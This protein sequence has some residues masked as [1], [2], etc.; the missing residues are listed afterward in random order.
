[1]KKQTPFQPLL[2]L[3]VALLLLARPVRA[4][5]NPT[6]PKTDLGEW[7]ILVFLN[8]DNNLEPDALTNFRQMAQV[9][10]NAKVNIIV[11]FDRNGG[12]ASTNPNWSQTLRF[13][14]HQGIQPLP[15]G[16]IQDI[17]EAN[18]GDGA[19][20][21]D[22]VSWG[23]QKYPAKH[24]MLDIW[25]HGSGWK[26]PTPP[27]ARPQRLVKKPVK[28]CSY[29][30]SSN[31]ELYNAELADALAQALHGQKLDLIGFDCCLMEMIETAYAIRKVGN[32]MV[33]SED[34]EPGDG[35][36]Y[37]AWLSDLVN[38]PTM[39]A[40]ALGKALVV[41]YQKRY[42][43]V[44]DNGFGDPTTTLAEFDLTQTEKLAAD[45]SAL[46]VTLNNTLPDELENIRASRA[47]CANFDP[48]DAVIYNIDLQRFCTQLA[49]RTQNPELTTR[50][51]TVNADLASS[52]LT[53]YHGADR[54]G[55]FGSFGLAIYFPRTGALYKTDPIAS[56]GGY[57]KIPPNATP[58]QKGKVKWPVA[59]VQET[60][61][62]DF[63]HNYFKAAP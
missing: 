4:G 6:N 47:D 9:P 46:A 7:T 60:A 53:N 22:F 10:D 14:I 32:I 37:D 29:D 11:E 20:L 61:W 35:W 5:N 50:L 36:Q 39:D 16:A 25:D 33:G 13:K 56:G 34:S 23:M 40:A 3:T 49:S 17:G 26:S 44:P 19:T 59:F 12:Y 43:P 28:S 38:N 31:D 63:L 8:G 15:S 51:Q 42:S 52:V 48:N 2:Y 30:E 41:S 45:I 21:R 18:M 24:Y 57:E 54:G 62:P 1:M 27:G 58:E 55:T